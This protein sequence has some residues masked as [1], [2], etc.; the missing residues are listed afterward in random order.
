MG[1]RIAEPMEGAVSSRLVQL[2][3]KLGEGEN[4]GGTFLC[5]REVGGSDGGSKT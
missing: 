5:V 1:A 4:S 3:W 2:N